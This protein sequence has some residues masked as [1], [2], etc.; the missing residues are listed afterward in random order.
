MIDSTEHILTHY[1][2]SQKKMPW[3][4]KSASVKSVI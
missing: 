3:E 4:L 1:F 2:I